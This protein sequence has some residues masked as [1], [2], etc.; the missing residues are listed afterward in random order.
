MKQT[1]LSFGDEHIPREDFLQL[2]YIIR[3]KG[4]KYSV[5]MG[6]VQNREEATSFLKKVKSNKKYLKATHNTFA[7]RISKDDSIFETKQD[8]GE[9]GAGMVILREMR[10]ANIMNAIIVVTRWYGGTKLGTDRFRHVKRA[11]ELAI[12]QIIDSPSS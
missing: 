5:S 12:V 4:T 8:D 11:A 7:V 3:D 10:R 2:H 9:T 6:R 1:Q